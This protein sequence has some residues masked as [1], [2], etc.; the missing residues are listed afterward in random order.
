MDGK[1]LKIIAQVAL[2]EYKKSREVAKNSLT[3]I[4][5]AHGNFI[6]L[7]PKGNKTF[8]YVLKE[9]EE[10]YNFNGFKA[11]GEQIF[12]LRYVEGD[13]LFVCTQQNLE[14]YERDYEFSFFS[15]E[16]PDEADIEQMNKALEYMYYYMK[17]DDDFIIGESLFSI[18][19]AIQSYL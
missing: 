4:V 18:L 14:E 11:E 7:I 9:S 6:P 3:E 2:D 5:K 17:F 15:F 12:G 1:D 19:S 13:G 8:V 16:E 10:T